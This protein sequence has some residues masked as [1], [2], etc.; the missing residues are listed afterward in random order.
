MLGDPVGDPVQDL[1]ALLRNQ[2]CPSAFGGDGGVNGPVDIVCGT[3]EHLRDHRLIG[4]VDDV[5]QF[6]AC[7]RDELVGDEVAARRQVRRRDERSTIASPHLCKRR[8][9]SLGHRSMPF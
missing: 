2:L 4:G 1:G 5:E 9:D 8:L 3:D 7:V 6:T